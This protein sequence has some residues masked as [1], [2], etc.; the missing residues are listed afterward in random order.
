MRLNSSLVSRLALLVLCGILAVPLA[1]VGAQATPVAGENRD[2]SPAI[3]VLPGSTPLRV[4]GSDGLDHIEYDLIVINSFIAPVTLTRIEVLDGAGNI[5]TVL[6]EPQLAINT[7]AM[8]YPPSVMPIPANQAVAVVVGV[9][10]PPDQPV[11]ALTHRVEYTVPL[12]APAQS[13]LGT[14]VVHGPALDVSPQPEIV[15]A[16][17]LAGDGWLAANGCCDP[18]T[19]H[20]SIRLSRGTGI[21]KAE[22]FSIDWIR[23]ENGKAYEGDGSQ[24]EQWFGFGADLLAV[25][26]GIV[27]AARDDMP[28]EVPLQAPQ[29]LLEPNDYA[30]N[31]VILEIAPGLYA[32]YAHM[33]AGS[34]AVE[35][36]DRVSA[37]DVLG[38]LG[39][40]GST[41]GPHLHFGLLDYPDPFVGESVPMVFDAYTVTGSVSPDVVDQMDIDPASV[42]FEVTGGPEPQVETLQLVFTV[43]DFGE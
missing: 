32:F 1:F 18:T 29:H 28:D 4:S 20:R 7:Q 11:E 2:L 21:A 40:S 37:G 8:F 16:S 3:V 36:G 10:V 23:L 34:V 30:G 19:L 26:D 9:P 41:A 5:L 25:A 31:H 6:D 24:N 43:A 14:H 38:R 27:V 42:T 39:N 35:V 12:D 13:I 17:P 33:E 22:T 15:I